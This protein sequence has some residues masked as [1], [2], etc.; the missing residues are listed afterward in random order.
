MSWWRRFRSRVA[1][2]RDLDRELQDHLERRTQAL[3]AAG[4]TP[5]QARRQALVERGGAEQV[6]EAV[7]D[8]RGTRWAHD[9]A[10]D[11]RYGLRSLRKSPGLVIA[12]LLSMGL[13]IGANAAI[14]S[15]VDAL[16]LRALPVDRPGELVVVAG[17]FT[18]PIW[19]ALR[20]RMTGRVGG[21]LAWG[22][23]RLDLSK[24][25]ETDPVDAL[26]VSGRFFETLGVRP[27][28]GRLLTADDDRRGGGPDGPTL[29]VS[30]R[31][32]ERRFQRDPGVVG[33][34]LTVSGVPFTVVGVVPAR[35][36][37]PSVGRTFDVA[38]PIGT[39]D[40]VRP[41]GPQ[42][43]LDG[44]AT[45]W[46]NIML[47][48]QPDQ[49]I[50]ATTAALRGVQPQIRATTLPDWPAATLAERYLSTPFR[51][52]PA[53][54]GLSELRRHYREPLL[55][56]VGIVALVL[57]IACANVANLLLA[58]AAARRH[59]LAARLAL[60]AS[61]GRLV[62]QL[63]TESLLLAVPGAVAGLLLAVWGA[64]FLVA[65][66]ATVDDPVALALPVDWRLFGFMAALSVLT[67][68]GFGLAPAWRARRL[69]AAE[70]VAH[71]SH[72]R[73][74]RRGAVSG[75]LVV[76]Q[77]ALSL[78]LVVAAGLF[79]RTFSTLASRDIGFQPEGLQIAFVEAGRVA[80][81]RRTRLY[82][83]LQQAAT[84]V[85]G[86]QAAAV[87]VIGPLS[88]MGWNSG[89]EVA[90]EPRKPGREA[91]TYLNAVTPRWFATYGTRLIAGR[92]FEAHD[93][94]APPVSIVNEAFARHFFG[95]RPAVGRR[96]RY[97]HGAGGMT[98]AEIVGVVENAAYRGLR[99]AFPPTMYR[100]AAQVSDPP[101]F[102]SLT[103]RTTAGG[104]PGLQPALT[105]AIQRVEPT[106]AV[107]YRTLAD[108]IHDQLTEVRTIA[109]LSSFFGALALVLA[110]I[111]LYGVTSYGVNERRREIGIRLTLG[112]G[113]AAAERFVLGRVARL[114]ALGV[115]LGLAASV[116]LS[117]V[118]RTLLYQLEPRD[119]ATI[120]LAA[121]TLTIVGLLA[122]WLPARRAARI[123]PAQVLREG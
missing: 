86:V 94:A 11:M 51:L 21:A 36:L 114:V 49:P 78:V 73:T 9:L 85:P 113:R 104:T 44:R 92:D 74:T 19:E 47:R 67:A 3:I 106:L 26:M 109:L 111:G 91:M 120:A 54:T 79:G 58:R 34:S 27:A 32:W 43:A 107:T 98:E 2:D 71:T 93:D 82:A 72:N 76:G 118:V 56:L 90:G 29:V 1:L 5:A 41:G 45:W 112:A 57:L 40:L 122:G 99:D 87:S 62:R 59:E 105:R 63:L 121:I 17:T 30:E 119:P 39:I 37:G 55:V 69:G 108:R 89:A 97:E 53:S 4:L 81:E 65:Q 10:Q 68:V 6:K 18:N 102:L 75:P 15:L 52:E 20:D 25:G 13:G 117:P 28:L 16:L 48:R 64:R 95:T 84:A 88:G 22:E 12:A 31:F 103:V 8:V 33:R 42:S 123:D 24:G 60:G 46:L 116:A 80:P 23:E 14:F 100:P 50:D 77:I 61:H 35:F 96:V 70:A 7:R 66:I 110:A 83:E 38:A 115:A 101:P